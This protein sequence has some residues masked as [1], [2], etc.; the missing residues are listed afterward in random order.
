MPTVPPPSA[1][2]ALRGFALM[3]PEK[4]KEIARKGGAAVLPHNRS[5]SRD[6]DLAASAGSKGGEASRGGGRQPKAAE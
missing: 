4:R 1:P 5:F 6:R 2:K 3:S